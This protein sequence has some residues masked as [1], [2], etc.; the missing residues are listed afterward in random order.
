L[1]TLN[2][3]SINPGRSTGQ[4]M[5]AS[6]IADGFSIEVYPAVHMEPGTHYESGCEVEKV[7]RALVALQ[8]DRVAVVATASSTG[9]SS[10]QAAPREPPGSM[11]RAFFPSAKTEISSPPAVT[12]SSSQPV[13]IESSS[14]PAATVTAEAEVQKEPVEQALAEVEDD[15]TRRAKFPKAD[16]SNPPDRPLGPG[17]TLYDDQN[18]HCGK[19]WAYEGERGCWWTTLSVGLVPEPYVENVVEGTVYLSHVLLELRGRGR[20]KEASSCHDTVRRFC[21][22]ECRHLL[23]RQG[24]PLRAWSSPGG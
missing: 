13:V 2:A 7:K 3:E 12:E 6:L 24:L 14:Q 15:V 8:R 4:L 16:A 17:W 11:I 23:S 10:S 9:A 5:T 19:W 21:A 22:H 1:T 18:D 20:A